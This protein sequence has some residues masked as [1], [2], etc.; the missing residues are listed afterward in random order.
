MKLLSWP[1]RKKNSS[2]SKIHITM[3]V[4]VIQGTSGPR[5]DQFS[6][7]LECITEDWKS[8]LIAY[9]KTIIPV[10]EYQP[11]L[12]DLLQYQTIREGISLNHALSVNQG[13][14]VFRFFGIYL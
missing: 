11:L 4:N 5:F 1:A 2:E 13:K 8:I 12:A 10:C 3:I 7:M 14:A 9:D 6:T